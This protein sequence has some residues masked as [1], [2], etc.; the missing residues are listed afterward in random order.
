MKSKKPEKILN[1]E[2]RKA[3]IR[4]KVS[5]SKEKPRLSVFRS[6]KNI[7]AQLIDDEKRV[8]LCSFS[9]LK[10]KKGKKL[11]RAKKVGE[12]LAA[13]AKAK[14]ISNCVFDRNGYAYHGRVKVL[15][16]TAREKGLKF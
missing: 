13:S 8:T 6:N 3:R 5:G 2:R 9:D 1:R 16:D 12:E 10:I 11:E 14:K 4:A 7:Y 15:A